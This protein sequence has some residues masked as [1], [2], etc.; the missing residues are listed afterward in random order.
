MCVLVNG[1]TQQCI[2]TL[3]ASLP[4]RVFTQSCVYNGYR[5]WHTVAHREKPHALICTEWSDLRVMMSD[6]WKSSGLSRSRLLG[7]HRRT[8][9]IFML[10][11]DV[12]RQQKMTERSQTSGKARGLQSRGSQERA[13]GVLVK[14]LS[15]PT[16][17]SHWLQPTRLLH[18][19]NFPGKS[20][21]VGGHSLLQG[22]FWARDQ[23]Q[24]SLV[25]GRCFTVWATREALEFWALSL[26]CV[27][28]FQEH[29]W[30]GS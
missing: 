28:E 7:K 9:H 23:T 29:V 11:I 5:V 24:V 2:F 1:H 26:S 21:G 27:S 6:C 18:P 3:I 4:H 17:W 25:A 20:T 14:L 10:N 13:L 8:Q 22:I 12:L 15:C 16:L 30:N 19:C